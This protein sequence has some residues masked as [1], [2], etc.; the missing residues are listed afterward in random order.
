MTLLAPPVAPVLKGLSEET[1]MEIGA[2]GIRG[3]GMRLRARTTE[4]CTTQGA[5]ASLLLGGM[6]PSF[7]RLW[8]TFVS[9]V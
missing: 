2:D 8:F 3:D 5:S 1:T 4:G 6:T 7:S 9:L